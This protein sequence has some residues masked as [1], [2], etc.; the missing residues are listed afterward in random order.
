MFL[1]IT[2]SIA[3]ISVLLALISLKKQNNLKEIKKVKKELAKKRVIYQRDS[4]V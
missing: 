3:L 2:I 4:S 1:F